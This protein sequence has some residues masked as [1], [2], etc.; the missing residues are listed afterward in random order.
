M[1]EQTERLCSLYETIFDILGKIGKLPM[2][3]SKK[4]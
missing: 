3:V 2:Y 1:Y 4:K